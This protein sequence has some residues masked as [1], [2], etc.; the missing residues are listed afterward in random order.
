MYLNAATFPMQKGAFIQL[1]EFVTDVNVLIFENL[2]YELYREAIINSF[3]A[4]CHALIT[5]KRKELWRPFDIQI[6]E[7]L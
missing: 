4:I 3:E 2:K 7:K 6:D 5:G 1:L